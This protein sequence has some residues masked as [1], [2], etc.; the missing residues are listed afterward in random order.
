LFYPAGQGY[1]ILLK[2]LPRASTVKMVGKEFKKFGA[3]KPGGIQVWD[4]EVGNS[5]FWYQLCYFFS[6][7]LT[8]F[9]LQ[10]DKFR[11]GIVEFE[12]RESMEAAIK[13][14][15]F[16]RLSSFVIDREDLIVFLI[17]I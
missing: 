7:I 1:S 6:V 15:L 3:I 9:L 4:N 14:H 11:S 2:E 12:F 8:F 5:W 16:L 17:V 10:F 13:V